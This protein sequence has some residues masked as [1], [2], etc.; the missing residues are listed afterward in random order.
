MGLHFMRDVPFRDVYIHALVRD[1]A[2]QKMSKSKGNVLD[3][4]ELIDQYG[5]DAL[6]FTLAALAAQGRDIKLSAGR[7]EGYRNFVTKLWNAARYA[8]MNAAGRIAAQFDPASCT[9]TVNRWIVGELSGAV[10]AVDEAI[11]EYKF[12]DAA[13]T[14]YHFTWHTFCDWY[15]EFTK[16]ILSGGNA[17]QAAEVRAT[18]AWVLD[19][20]LHLLHPFM[21]FVTEE[22]W[23]A[24]GG[25]DL[26]M[27]RAWPD[28]AFTD[29]AAKQEM[30]W[31][32]R[33]IATIR[34][35]R[36]EMNVPAAAKIPLLLKD[37]SVDAQ[38]RLARHRDLILG[39][40]RLASAQAT[41]APAP[42]G[43]VQAVIDGATLILPLA[44]VI[45]IG[46]ERA[47]LAKEVKRLET[48][49]EKI[50]RKLGNAAFIDRAPA[51]VVEENRERRAEFETSRTKLA[52]AAARLAAV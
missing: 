9:L 44:E 19:R 36:S 20:I 7:I 15:L 40:A 8:E 28:A 18:T 16:P 43:A 46:A 6:R 4:L 30:D 5:A 3:P 10:R 47:R 38:E 37:A 39:L 27:L 22:L 21:P 42:K 35:V 1:E 34:G 12:N 52:E 48:E 24:R 51:E 45:D 14:L 11:A 25:N 13:G 50:D 41:D 29:A 49:I 26:L 33:L 31:V 23:A 2:G 17:A 32:V